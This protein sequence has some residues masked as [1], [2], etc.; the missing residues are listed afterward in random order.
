MT[1]SKKPIVFISYSRKD[2]S[3]KDRLETQLKVF[4]WSF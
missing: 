1:G 3:W 4:G 2:E